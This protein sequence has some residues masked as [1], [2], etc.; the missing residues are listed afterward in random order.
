MA[1]AAAIRVDASPEIGTGHVMRCLT[2]A[3]RLRAAGWAP[4]FLSGDRPG[5]LVDL[6]RERGF[7]LIPL[8]ASGG[9][10]DPDGP[11]HA[12]WLGAPAGE[13]ARHTR[14]A[15]ETIGA[16][17][18]IVDH[19]ALD[20]RWEAQVGFDPART[21]VIDD[22]ADRP[23]RCALLVD[24]NLGRKAEDYVALVGAETDILAGA[25]YALL[26]P[27]FAALRAGSLAR[28]AAPRL[29]RILVAMGGVDAPN[30][31]GGIL[32]ALASVPGAADLDVT[33]VLG[34][35]ALWLDEVRARVADFPGSARLL[36]GAGNMGEL[37][38]A[39]D[40]AVGGAGV[41]A[42]E[43]CCLGL[44]TLIVTIAEN[45]VP[46]ARALD[47]AGAGWMIGG[48]ADIEARLASGVERMRDTSRLTAMSRAAAAVA[49]GRGAERV[50]SRLV[51]LG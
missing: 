13:D 11:A 24:A 23:H 20:A 30:A 18:L 46:G 16:G 17:M 12:H 38:A 45:Q 2:L 47:A 40:L 4:V 19:Y 33:T 21:A 37:M 35:N 6:I 42:W 50:V 9:A 48:V 5:N 43:R 34:P 22:L 41:T 10:P 15:I 7:D 31:T 36:I 39:S 44:P 14:I 51:A 28:R 25:E 8:P 26:R 32:R 27:E 49:D 3:E 1:R 29:E